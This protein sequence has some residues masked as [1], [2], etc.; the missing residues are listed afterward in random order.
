MQ[1]K[2]KCFVKYLSAIAILWMFSGQLVFAQQSDFQLEQAREHYQADQ[3]SKVVE[4]TQPMLDQPFPQELV[5]QLLASSYLHLQKTDQALVVAVEGVELYYESMELRLMKVQALQRLNPEKAIREMVGIKAE[6]TEGLL[7]SQRVS[8]SDLDQFHAQLLMLHARDQLNR[9]NHW[10]AV[11]H[12]EEAAGLSPGSVEVYRQ[13]LYTHMVAEDY[14]NLL[15]RFDQIPVE[16]RG[17]R[18]LTTLRNRALFELEEMDEL[19]ASYRELYENGSAD[20][21]ETLMYGQLLYANNEILQANELFNELLEN[22]PRERV[23][24]ELLL[25]VNQKQMNFEGM[26]VLL[27]QM[28]GVFPE[29]D[30]IPLQLAHIREMQGATDEAIAIYDSLISARGSQFDLVNRKAELVYQQGD[31]QEAYELLK[32]VE[33]SADNHKIELSLGLIAG[34]LQ[35][36]EDAVTHFNRYLEAFPEDSLALTRLARSHSRMGNATLAGE[37]YQQSINH[38]SVWPEAYIHTFGNESVTEDYIRAFDLISAEIRERETG[39][40]IQARLA[41]SGQRR[42]AGQLFYHESEQLRDIKASVWDLR[43]H[44]FKH[45]SDEESETVLLALIE[46]HKESPLVARLLADF[47]DRTGHDLRA[48]DIYLESIEQN[49]Q[50]A[51]LLSS[52][53]ELQESRGEVSDALLWYERLFGVERSPQIYRALIRLHREQGTLDQLSD[54]WLTR[55]RS[56]TTDREFREFL[57]E[58]LHKAERFE[59]A[60]EITSR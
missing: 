36:D 43:E 17:D 3:Y 20:L 26:A 38:G 12:L 28:A 42:G 4:L 6:M 31:K 59:E 1:M 13:L 52:V 21:D 33:P 49:P 45:L 56:R 41:L 47:Y 39:L 55:Y 22:H 40:S 57:I 19:R 11:E 25:E 29:E 37:I 54:R 46:G 18:Q 10:E 9:L 23:I 8:T 34:S 30:E 16:M 58:A 50:N 44:M 53:A 32:E 2:L 24:Y 15:E 51:D 5:F 7:T 60:R 35:M 14:E 27:E 48:L